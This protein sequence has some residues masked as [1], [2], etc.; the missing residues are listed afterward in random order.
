ML[1]LKKPD[2]EANRFAFGAEIRLDPLKL[3]VGQVGVSSAEVL[4]DPLDCAI[5]RTKP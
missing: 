3:I 4:L 1:M 2:G 5:P